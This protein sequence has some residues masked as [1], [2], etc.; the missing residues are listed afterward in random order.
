MYHALH[1]SGHSKIYVIQDI[2]IPY[3]ALPDFIDYV[4]NEFG[5]YPLWL[6]PLRQRGQHEN[7]PYGLLAEKPRDGGEEMMM[8][9]GIWGPGPSDHKRFI[10]WNQKLEWKVLDLKGEKWLYAHAYYTEAEFWTMY[11]RKGYDGLREKHLISRAFTIRLKW[12][13]RQIHQLR[14]A[15]G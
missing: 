2:A 1:K 8:N 11:D 7:S 9:V 5:F 14:N 12:R 10:E 13:C 4:D 15:L 3:P 6:C